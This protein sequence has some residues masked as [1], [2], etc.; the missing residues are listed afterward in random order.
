MAEK[1]LP[2]SGGCLCGAVRYEVSD[3][4]SEGG[5][6]HCRVCQKTT[7]SAF[8]A[9]IGCLQTSFRYTKGEPKRYRSSS[10]MEKSFC[11]N[12]GSPLT[13]QYI[14]S[15]SEFFSNDK[16]W[17]HIGTLDEP[18][19]ISI[20]LHT[21]VESQMPW[22]HFDDG[23]PRSRCDEDPELATAFAAGDAVKEKNS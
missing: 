7:G 4:P 23:N 8:E 2:I 22:L 14:V 19:A 18:T 21:G 12:C 9:L 15:A 5:L 3:P 10:I 17:V 6:C 1:S 13:D 11:S 20:S 16:V